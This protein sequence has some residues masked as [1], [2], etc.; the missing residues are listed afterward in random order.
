MNLLSLN[1]PRIFHFTRRQL[2]IIVVLGAPLLGLEWLSYI[3]QHDPNAFVQEKSKQRKRAHNRDFPFL[4]L[5]YAKDY[6]AGMIKV[7]EKMTD[8]DYKR[9]LHL[10]PNLPSTLEGYRAMLH[11]RLERLNAMSKTDFQAEIDQRIPPLSHAEVRNAPVDKSKL[12]PT[13]AGDG[14]VKDLRDATERPT[15]PIPTMPTN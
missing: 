2:L 4:T 3:N 6:T 13:P 7:A 10:N 12:P 1:L 14:V 15:M 8:S 5:D 9:V 11:T